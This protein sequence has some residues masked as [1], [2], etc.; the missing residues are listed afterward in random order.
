MTTNGWRI[1]ARTLCSLLAALALG[2]VAAPDGEAASAKAQCI[3]SV[4][5]GQKKLCLTGFKGQFSTAKTTCGA[6]KQCKKTAKQSFKTNKKR[7]A[8]EFKNCKTCCAGDVTASCSVAV[9]GDGVVVTGEEC[10]QGNGN[11]NVEPDAC[12]VNCRSAFCGD[13]VVDSGEECDPPSLGAC[14]DSCVIVEATTTT[15]TVSTTTT[16]LPRGCGDGVLDVGEECDDGN[17]ITTDGCT[18]ACTECGNATVTAP[19]TCDDGDLDSGDGCD[20]NCTST[21]C[22]NGIVTAPE[23]CDDG[24]ESDDDDCPGDCVVDL[25]DPEIGSDRPVDV[26]VTSGGQVAGLTVLLVYPEGKVRIPGSGGSIPAGIVTDVAGIFSSSND[27]D[28]ALRQVVAGAFPIADGLLFRVHFETCRGAPG[29]TLS[30]FRCEVLAANDATGTELADVACRVA[31]VPAGATTTTTSAP[32][33][34]STTPTTQGTSTTSSSTTSST[35]TS[36][37]SSSTTTI[38]PLCGNGQV[39]AGE[40]CD[41][42]NRSD[43]DACPGDCVVDACT[44]ATGT[45]RPFNVVFTPQAGVNVGGITVLVDYPEGRVEIPGPPIPGGTI[46][47]LPPGAF[48]IPTDLDHALRMIVAIGGGSALP[49]GVLF[50]VNYRDCAGAPPPGPADFRCSVLEATDP[51]S[52]P[53]TNEVTCATVAP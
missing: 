43:N 4:C 26:E 23:T 14:D 30:D 31:G 24:N 12:R 46:T 35:T 16:T 36:T 50:R 47:S 1:G 25:C 29:P 22:G 28:H 15:V 7:C 20:A 45:V 41:D 48:P 52:N 51:F 42:G 10:D 33:S 6:A 5:T 17:E 2:A 49:P 9:C 37:T 21:G 39:N 13:G 18:G 19:E 40:T 3:K 27:L 32:S 8:T 38:S 53:V 44:P 11:S 34:T